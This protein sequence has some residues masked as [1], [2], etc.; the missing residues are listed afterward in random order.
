MRL[1]PLAATKAWRHAVVPV[2]GLLTTVLHL[3][4]PASMALFTATFPAGTHLITN[5][6]AYRN[7]TK[8]DAV[9]S[10]DWIATSGS[11]FGRNGTGWT[12]PVDRVTP[13]PTSDPHT[14]SA[15]FRLI[16]RRDDFDDAHVQFRLSIAGVTSTAQTP[17]VD[18]DGVHIWM[19]YQDQ[20]SSYAVSVA[21]RDGIVLIKKKCP[22]G[23]TNGG[24]YHTLTRE[25]SGYPIPLNQWRYVGATAYNTP[26]G[27][28]RVT[29]LINGRFVVGVTD[30]GIGCAPIRAAGAVGIRGDNAEF[31]FSAFTVYPF[32]PAPA[33]P[34]Q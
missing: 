26:D 23:P 1:G 20:T 5:E 13:G 25:V 14:D 10:P 3:V 31:S 19:R 16:T 15:V 8:P 27:G 30:N 34:S 12:G 9:T 11:L 6:Y 33:V 24:T 18:W 21:R 22:G 7:P 2:M 29:M 4:N 32:G 17:K 28:V